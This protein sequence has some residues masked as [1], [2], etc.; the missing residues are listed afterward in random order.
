[1]GG[2]WDVL[3]FALVALLGAAATAAISRRLPPTLAKLIWL[4]FLL[5][6]VGSVVR[7]QTLMNQYDGVGDAAGYYGH[8]LA[9]ADYLRSLDFSIFDEVYWFGGRFIGTQFVRY[10]SAVVL[11]FIGPTMVGEF[12]AF[13]LLSFAGLVLIGLAYRRQ[14][15]DDAGRAL[16]RWLMLWPT[17]WFWPSSVGKEALVVF[18]AGL[19][20][21]GAFSGSRRGLPL[22]GIGTLLL[23]FVRPHFAAMIGAGLVVA[24]VATFR[25]AGPT[26]LFRLG[27][28]LVFGAVVASGTSSAMGL[29]SFDAA[30]IE[31]FVDEKTSISTRGGSNFDQ[32]SGL[33]AIPYQV[34]T[35]LFRPFLWE[36]H[37]A[38][39]LV[40][41]LEMMFMWTV[42]FR[43][44]VSLA[45][46]LRSWRRSRLLAYALFCATLLTVAFGMAFSNL[47]IIARQRTIILPFLFIIIEG[48]ALVRAASLRAGDARGAP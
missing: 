35:V 14:A 38:Q 1:M 4:G 24:E 39:A 32:G 10:V 12:L 2:A 18:G 28:L 22:V 25:A 34:I 33:G 17:L 27:G 23:F 16:L 21:A 43:R 30:A 41:S 48:G 11:T 9:Y 37:N 19:V 42:A 47:G 36:A 20:T 13:S 44:R 3:G 40:A 8:G 31:D 6:I 7:Y 29:D 5:R 45:E 46:S 26:Q 15:G